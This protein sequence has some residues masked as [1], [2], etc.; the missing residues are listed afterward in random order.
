MGGGLEYDSVHAREM[1][2]KAFYGWKMHMDIITKQSPYAFLIT[3]IA[4]IKEILDL[5][6]LKFSSQSAT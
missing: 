5:I 3:E 4:A 2:C 1:A 6:F